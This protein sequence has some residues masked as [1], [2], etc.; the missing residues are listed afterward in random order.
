MV[1]NFV[2]SSII[3]MV[4]RYYCPKLCFSF[5]R[6]YCV[7]MEV[8]HVE[9][10]SIS[11]EW[12]KFQLVLLQASLGY[13]CAVCCERRPITLMSLICH[14]QSCIECWNANTT[15]HTHC[16]NVSVSNH[17][18]ACHCLKW[19]ARVFGDVNDVNTRV[20]L[21]FMW[22]RENVCCILKAMGYRVTVGL[23]FIFQVYS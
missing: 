22:S 11:F 14:S 9:D 3:I 4:M 19:C 20:G 5:I 10:I 1:Q 13:W 2:L 17:I 15:L 23:M 8:S 6:P 18:V 12:L 21:L 7:I 16:T